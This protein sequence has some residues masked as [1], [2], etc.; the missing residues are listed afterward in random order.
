MRHE[1]PSAMWE[2][3]R[4]SVEHVN[5]ACGTEEVLLEHDAQNWWAYNWKRRGPNKTAAPV[6]FEVSGAVVKRVTAVL[7][8]TRGMQNKSLALSHSLMY[9]MLGLLEPET[10]GQLEFQKLRHKTRLQIP[11]SM[12]QCNAWTYLISHSKTRGPN[13]SCAL[14]IWERLGILLT[15]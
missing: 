4:K 1:K 12:S 5:T 10:V 8:A 15:M 2:V 7:S 9:L 14:T 3:L 11:K 6:C 13:N